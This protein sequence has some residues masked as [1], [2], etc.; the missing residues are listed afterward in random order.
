MDEFSLILIA[1]FLFA[2]GAIFGGVVQSS[3]DDTNMLTQCKR[4]GQ[5][6]VRDE[7]VKCAVS[8]NATTVKQ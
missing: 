8:D 6:I 7:M 2:V 5:I 3:R 1:A 4:I